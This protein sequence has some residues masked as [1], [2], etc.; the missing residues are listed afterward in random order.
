MRM[1][2]EDWADVIEVNLTATMRLCKGVRAGHDEGALGAD[3]QHLLRRGAHGQPGAG[4]LCR[5][6]GR[7]WSPCRSPRLRGR[8][9][10]I[11]VNCVAPGFIETAMTDKLTEDQKA[12]ILARFRRAAWAR[13]R[14]SRP[15]SST[16]R[17][18]EAAYV[19]GATLHVNG[20]MAMV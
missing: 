20:G 13:P 2:D 10:G 18:P 4:E 12:A 5:V 3:R 1:S 14:K 7:A 17:S 11:T 19:T 8:L 15:P 6:Q 16:L 9:R